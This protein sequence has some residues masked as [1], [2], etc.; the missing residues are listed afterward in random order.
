MT[1]ERY[2]DAAALDER[3]LR[4]LLEDAR[5]ERRMW[6]V[7]ALALARGD[8]ALGARVRSEPDPGVRRTLAVVLAG[9]QETE[10]LVALAQHDPVFVVRESAM[11]LVTRFVASGAI[12]MEVL[13][14]A[15]VREPALVPAILGA[16]GSGA[17]PVL[18]G[19]AMRQ[20]TA[21]TREVQLEALETLLRIDTEPT[22]AQARA[23][24][25]RDD[26]AAAAC[27]R[28][29]RAASPES[30][31]AALVGASRARRL[32]ALAAMRAPP[33]EAVA[34]LVEEDLTSLATVLQR[35]D[36]VVPVDVLAAATLR[37]A[38]LPFLRR[39]TEQLDH[40]NRARPLLAAVRRAIAQGGPVPGH[41]AVLAAEAR[42]VSRAL[43]IANA[44]PVLDE[45]SALH[46][47]EQLVGLEHAVAG[48]VLA[49]EVTGDLA[50]WESP[51]VTYAEARLLALEQ[52]IA[53]P[54]ALAALQLA[55]GNDEDW[56][57]EDWDDDVLG[58]QAIEVGALH[59]LLEALARHA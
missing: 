4:A 42:A 33:W 41:L 14:A 27:S 37:E 46:P 56:D 38:G 29:L 25:V 31:A 26:D 59:A 55:A 30:L 12:T 48:W 47:V 44:S 20:L 28:W 24:L 16:V 45:L 17:P 39:L 13:L 2:E 11:Q 40:A 35:G 36:I 19:F 8:G 21:G 57:D 22:R 34:M 58:D 5:P 9:R 53:V 32:T 18:V 50:P 23:W 15:E 52:V 10:L 51:L 6:A 49:S 1:I 3:A 43:D 54:P 7:W